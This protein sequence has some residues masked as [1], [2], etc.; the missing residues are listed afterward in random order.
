M[1]RLI[2]S[3]MIVCLVLVSGC[4]RTYTISVTKNPNQ[5]FYKSPAIMVEMASIDYLELEGEFEYQLLAKGFNVTSTAA[6]VTKTK[7]H[8]DMDYN[9][10]KA[11]GGRE[12][13]TVR[14]VPA[15]YIL[16]ISYDHSIYYDQLK[17]YGSLRNL[18][19]GRNILSLK[20]AGDRKS[21]GD[22]FRPDIDYSKVVEEV[23]EKLDTMH[24]RPPQ[25]SKPPTSNDVK[26]AQLKKP[27]QIRDVLAPLAVV[28]GFIIAILVIED[29][30]G[31][32]K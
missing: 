2:G 3:S 29:H 11:Q 20:I 31:E 17:L 13:Y 26:D 19:T 21:P 9:R 4:A 6:G 23:I 18:N 22:L 32:Q 16:R 27:Q 5:V 24:K 7:Y 8:A 1:L 28:G 12:T 15:Y 10:G 30:Q 25:P 14:E